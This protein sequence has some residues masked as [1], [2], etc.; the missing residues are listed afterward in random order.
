[1]AIG[2]L[3]SAQVE[4]D[5]AK[6]RQRPIVTLAAEI[7]GDGSQV[8]LDWWLREIN[9][10]VS[11]L[12]I[13]FDFADP[14]SPAE[15]VDSVNDALKVA[16]LQRRLAEAQAYITDLE[17]NMHEKVAGA[18]EAQLGS[19]A[20]EMTDEAQA[21]RAVDTQ[22]FFTDSSG[23]KWVNIA[24]EAKRTGQLYV[25][26]WRAAKK[27]TQTTSIESWVVGKTNTKDDRILVKQG[28]FIKRKR[29]AK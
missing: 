24:D 3:L 28:S 9:R 8:S 12:N 21:L 17:D 20:I 4:R 22:G 15:I 19:Q 11:P 16:H 2:K 18:V 27:L 10:V 26:I 6:R 5:K 1:M 29:G 23:A 25:T 13:T 7:P 14:D